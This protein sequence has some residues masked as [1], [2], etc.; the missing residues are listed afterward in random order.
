MGTI[1]L[2]IG[3]VLLGIAFRESAPVAQSPQSYV[4]DFVA[5]RSLPEAVASPSSKTAPPVRVASGNWTGQ[6]GRI[7]F[8]V[9]LLSLDRSGYA[10]GDRVVFEVL[11]KHVGATPFALPWAS[12]PEAVRGASRVQ[13]AVF[14]LGFTDKTLGSQLIGSEKVLY[15]ASSV[16]GSVLVLKPGDTVRVRAEGRWWLSRAFPEPPAGGWL[17]NVSVSA[18]LQVEGVNDFIPL[19]DSTNALRIQLLQ[20]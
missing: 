7:P 13:S 20:E 6:A 19:V 16:P 14:L 15:G 3:L 1:G 9:T 4:L 5:E 11:L 8:E 17:R 2:R 10:L 18:Q 12:D